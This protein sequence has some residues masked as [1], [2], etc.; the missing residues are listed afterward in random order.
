M[1]V[2]INKLEINLRGNMLD[3]EEINNIL[4][5]VK[6]NSNFLESLSLNLSKNK[7]GEKSNIS[8]G[9]IFNTS[10]KL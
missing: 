5:E 6:K 8:L 2:I 4:S 3:D 1:N 9:N 7:F 10:K